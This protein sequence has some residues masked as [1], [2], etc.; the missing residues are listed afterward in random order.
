MNIPSDL[1]SYMECLRTLG[2]LNEHTNA[3]EQKQ[4]GS[5]SRTESRS[6]RPMAK[7]RTTRNTPAGPSRP[8]GN[9][10][11]DFK[12]KAVWLKEIPTEV[13]SQRYADKV[14][15]R[16]GEKSHKWWKCPHENP[17]LPRNLTISSVKRRREVSSPGEE[18]AAKRVLSSAARTTNSLASRIALPDTRNNEMNVI[19]DGE[20]SNIEIYD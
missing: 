13:K 11:L 15:M 17:V 12:N 18:P 6:N 4:S 2:H 3:Y 10:K 16:C 20:G 8:S 7:V 1:P 14:C 5:S 19:T 9:D